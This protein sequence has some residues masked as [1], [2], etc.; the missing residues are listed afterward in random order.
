MYNIK[1]YTPLNLFII[2]SYF[3]RG[4]WVFLS[5]QDFC[6]NVG[7]DMEY[8]DLILAPQKIWQAQRYK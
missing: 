2:Y 3:A 5:I 7:S 6:Q 8:P 4:K 1:G